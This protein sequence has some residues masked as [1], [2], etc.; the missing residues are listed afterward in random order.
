MSGRGQ[1]A[2]YGMF[3]GEIKGGER[4]GS[5]WFGEEQAWENRGI[6]GQVRCKEFAGLAM[7]VWPCP[8]PDQCRLSYLLIKLC[9]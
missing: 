2:L 5:G 4:E 7:S 3:R 1:D 8:A 9:F 6:K